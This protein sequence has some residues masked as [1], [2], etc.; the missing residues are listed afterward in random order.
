[1]GRIDDRFAFFLRDG[2]PSRIRTEE[3]QWGGVRVDGIPPLEHAPMIRAVDADYLLAE[4]PVFGIEVNGDARAYPLRIVD[5][6]EMANDTVGGVPVSL[7]Y[8]T[9]CGAAI[10]FDGRAPNGQTYRF[11]TSGF[12]YRSNKLMYDRTTGTLWNQLTGEPVL[13]ELAGEDLRLHVIPTVLS[14]WGD[15][16]AQHPDTLVLSRDT[17]VYPAEFYEPGVLYGGYFASEETMFPVWQRSDALAAK[18]FVYTLFLDGVP[19]AYDVATLANEQVVNDLLADTNVVLVATRGTSQAD[20]IDRRLGPVS[21]TNGGEVR[22][23]ARGDEVYFPGPDPYTLLD[24]AGNAWQVTEDA[25]IGTDG[26]RATRLSGHLAY[27]FGWF[28]FFPDTL[29][30]PE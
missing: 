26:Q 7:A 22:A 6:H 13:G 11:G 10:A 25:L 24:S 17:G 1:L 19:K 18:A 5:N 20:G 27:W 15:W 3:I 16:L 8:C 4:E 23:Y 21:Y 30:Y 12:L 29:L 9:L 14:A 2:I 28:A